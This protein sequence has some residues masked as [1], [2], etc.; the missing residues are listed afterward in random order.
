MDHRL[1][2]S[3]RPY[4]GVHVEASNL[5][6]QGLDIRFDPLNAVA[7]SDRR[8]VDG[9]KALYHVW[10]LVFQPLDDVEVPP[11][12]RRRFQFAAAAY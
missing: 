12:Q 11:C 4:Q 9:N 5:E 1:V 8:N 6:V 10:M 2:P 7:P 3:G